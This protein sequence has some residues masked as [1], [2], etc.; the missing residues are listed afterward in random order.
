MAPQVS[1]AFMNDDPLSICLVEVSPS[2]QIIHCYFSSICISWAPI[3]YLFP[4]S[5]PRFIPDWI[6][7]NHFLQSHIPPILLRLRSPPPFILFIGPLLLEHFSTLLWLGRGVYVRIILLHEFWLRH[8]RCQAAVRSIWRS[9]RFSFS[10]FHDLCSFGV[11][12]SGGTSDDCYCLL[13]IFFECPRTY[14]HFTLMYA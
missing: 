13:A 1:S 5:A 14:K 7:T 6:V 12:L 11:T 9:L 10:P 3:L 8:D 4:S 2:D